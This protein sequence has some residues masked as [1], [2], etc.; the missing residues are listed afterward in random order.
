M[1]KGKPC[2]S[3]NLYFPEGIS[4]VMYVLLDYPLILI[5]APMGYGKTTFVRE[6]LK[7]IDANI[8]WKKVSNKDLSSFWKS[9][10]RLFGKVDQDLAL[11]LAALDMPCD[12]IIGYEALSLIEEI[13][14]QKDT[15]MIIDDY[16][17]VTCTETDNFILLL[18][19]SEIPYLHL[20]LIARHT[21]LQG[22]E[23]LK[24]KG[25]L[26]HIKKE[27]FTFTEK[28]IKAYF[29]LC[30]IFLKGV[31]V[32]TLYTLTEGWISALYLI[33]L[34]YKENGCLDSSKDMCK[35]ME[36]TI[37]RHFTEEIKELLLSLSIFDNFSVEQAI[38]V[39][40]N[41]NAKN[42]LSEVISKNAFVNY[43]SIN[44]TYHIHNILMILLQEEIENRNLQ[45][46]LYQ[47][48]AQWFLE[49]EDYNLAQHYFYLCK[50]F[51]NIYIVLEK[52][53]QVAGNYVYKKEPLIKFFLE[54]PNQ[55]KENHHFA[56][57]ALAF[58][59]FTYNE[60]EIFWKVCEEF[61]ENIQKDQSMEEDDRNRLLSEY[62]LL[63]SFTEYNDIRKMS[64][65]HL[66]ACQLLKEPSCL[67]PRNGIW[68]FGSPS[69]LYMFYRES[70]ALENTIQTMFEAL[71]NYSLATNGNANG[72]EYCMKAEGYYYRGD[73]ENA[74]ITNYQAIN[75]AKT[76]RQITNIIC[77]LFLM[78]RIALVKGDF[79]YVL[80][81]MQDMYHE[82]TVAKEYFL[83]HTIEI[84]KGY[85][86]S[87]LSQT[88]G[89]CGWL[90]E[91]DYSS[92]HLLFPNYTM[93]NIIYGRTLLIKGEYHKLI[94]SMESFI[95]IASVYPNLLGHIHTYIYVAAAN[96]RI[97][98]Q[99]EALMYLEKA[100]TLAI[101]DKLYIPFVENCD[102]IKPLLQEFQK[103]SIYCEDIERI[104][105]LYE[106]YD[107]SIG[108]IKR[109]FFASNRARL[110]RR[111]MEIAW[112]AVDG[113]SN[114]EIGEKLFISPN[115]VKMAIK[116]I[117]CKLSI[118]N[119][120]LLKDYMEGSE[121]KISKEKTTSTGSINR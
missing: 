24:L 40:K 16:H 117:Y 91:G 50:D 4:K 121:I 118:N 86:Y 113:L 82:V 22:L 25:Y 57:L 100:L 92:D 120:L 76:K 42:L 30:G 66:K 43:D 51:E 104:F 9:F 111:E 59:L 15:V 98:R 73:F 41:R 65:H 116:S 6:S 44:K 106:I 47:S 80:V 3:K 64:I 109:K 61:L 52:E 108:M 17:F 114:K 75:R 94:G 107:K 29:C 39:S 112:L 14:L 12:S 20:I 72:G 89:I 101:P 71:P 19:K 26:L 53:K 34:N 60:M 62:E 87:L 103:E 46:D 31:Q 102:Y 105:R 8:L 28:D 18:A 55:V 99:R 90:E 2:N 35:L 37:Y 67:L 85:I 96:M 54:C 95:D 21:E 56:M 79:D 78:M 33:M 77:S 11:S 23:E 13:K 83:L 48:A 84:C 45:K 110:S 69:V 68:T 97:F 36:N 32:K 10:C 63:I 5:E 1:P 38:Y 58:E 7:D 49:I 74:L 88:H 115:T 81:L 70:G 93:L 27:V 119:R